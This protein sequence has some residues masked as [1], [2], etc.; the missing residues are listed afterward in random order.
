MESRFARRIESLDEVFDF[1]ERFFVANG[2]DAASRYAIGLAIEEVF[3]N[4]VKYNP[5]GKGELAIR[6]DRDADRAIIGLTDFD[7]APFDLTRAAEVN[8]DAPLE[9]RT[10][11]GLG[12]HLLRKL[13]DEMK[14]AHHEGE[15]T[16]TLV[17]NLTFAQPV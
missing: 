6:M 17:K 15:T 13:M 14:Y 2:L 5:G 8:T 12:I 16:I 7:S 1:A 9:E 10:P 11:G 3:T 4:M